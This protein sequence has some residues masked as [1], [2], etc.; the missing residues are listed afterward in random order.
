MPHTVHDLLIVGAGPV[1]LALALALKD[2]G[3]DVVLADARE[4]DAVANDPRTL[5]LAHGS[6]LTLERLGVWH[7]LDLTP[8]QTIHV[9]QQGGFGRTAIQ[10]REEGVPALGYVGSAGALARALRAAVD[11]AGIP[12]LDATEVA[13]PDTAATAAAP[14]DHAGADGHIVATLTPRADNAAADGG[15]RGARLLAC[16]E[17]GLRGGDA[18][19]IVARDYGQQ[20]LIGFV[21]AAGG[22]RHTAYERFTPDGPVALLPCG[23]R[24]A[25]VH[26]VP[27]AQA[28]ALQQ[29]DASQYLARLQQA[30]GARLP[31]ENAGERLAYPLGLRYR[32]SPIAHRTAWLGN[33]AQTLHPVAGQGFNLALRDVWGLADLLQPFNRRGGDPGDARLL[34]RYADA[35]RLDRN[36]TIHFTD[37]LVRL[38]SNDI[39]PLRHLRGAGLFL[40]DQLP[41][42]RS[43]VARRMMFGARAW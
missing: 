11:A 16:A 42:L 6:R 17:G 14:I 5:A 1:G 27:P 15:T 23:K 25:V 13:M 31:L 29:L 39:P 37:S 2:S 28:D 34:A 35:R 36:G 20:A 30:F 32:P 43:F 40:L 10:A 4:R 38:F 3:L 26:V 22:H 24:Y 18:A 41:P 21:D 9:S 7:Q 12:V 8:I 33:A 19:A